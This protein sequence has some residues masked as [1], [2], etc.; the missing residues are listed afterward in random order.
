MLRVNRF[1]AAIDMMAAGT[2]PPMPIAANATPANQSGK[3][4]RMSA[5]IAKF[6]LYCS[7][8][9]A[10]SGSD[11]TPAASAMKPVSARSPSRKEYAGR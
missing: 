9:G 3:E 6:D 11:A 1:E 4:C 5:G 2:R 10:N 7:N 8:W